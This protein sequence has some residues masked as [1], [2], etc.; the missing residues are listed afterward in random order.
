VSGALRSEVCSWANGRLAAR[1][2][3]C[4]Q[5]YWLRGPFVPPHRGPGVAACIGSLMRVVPLRPV[6]LAAV[7]T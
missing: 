4:Q 1:C 5:E 6:S 2:A 7:T 3:V